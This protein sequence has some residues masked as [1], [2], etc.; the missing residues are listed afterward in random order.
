VPY[1]GSCVCPAGFVDDDAVYGD[2]DYSTACSPVSDEDRV[3]P[4][5]YVPCLMPW[6]PFKEW[7]PL[8]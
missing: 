8:V 3:Q 2:Y 1:N 6:K 5:P 7:A 4:V